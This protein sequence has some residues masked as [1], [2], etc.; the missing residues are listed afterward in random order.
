MDRT[1]YADGFEEAIVGID[2]LC[3]PAR[4]IYDKNKMVEI[5]MEADDMTLE[6]AI[7]YLEYN[8]FCAYVGEGTPIYAHIGSRQEVQD[9]IDEY[10]LCPEE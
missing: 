1:L 9:L 7:E 5:L 2:Y 4:V 6:D 10:D 3:T 8:V